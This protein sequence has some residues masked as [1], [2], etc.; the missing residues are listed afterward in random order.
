MAKL[1]Q[2]TL[3]LLCQVINTTNYIPYVTIT[4]IILSTT[5]KYY[6]YYS[7]TTTTIITTTITNNDDDNYLY[8][9]TNNKVVGE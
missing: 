6:Y 5:T 8:P 3:Y 2:I 1:S 4:N 9:N 7:I